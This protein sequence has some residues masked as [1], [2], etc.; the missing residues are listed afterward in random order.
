MT[1]Q[2]EQHDELFKDPDLSTMTM[3]ERQNPPIKAMPTPEMPLRDWTLPPIWGE[4]IEAN[5]TY[6]EV[7][8][9]VVKDKV[10]HSLF[11]MFGVITMPNIALVLGY[12]LFQPGIWLNNLWVLA[13][14]IILLVGVIIFFLVSYHLLTTVFWAPAYEPIRFCRQDRKVYCYRSSRRGMNGMGVYH[15][16]K[17]EV[18]VYDWAQCRAEVRYA[19]RA[20]SHYGL[21][22]RLQLSFLDPL[23]NEVIQRFDIGGSGHV[24]PS[25]SRVYLWETIRRYMEK[26]PD[27][28]PAPVVAKRRTT[29]L[30]FIDTVNPFSMPARFAPRHGRIFGY[31]VAVPMWTLILMT[32]PSVLIHWMIHKAEHKVDWGDFAHTVFYLGPG[33]TAARAAAQPGLPGP[34]EAAAEVRRQ[35]TAAL[36]WLASVVLQ[37]ATIARWVA[38]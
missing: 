17:K 11:G 34:V 3:G 14:N 37:V 2:A 9:A 21:T 22:P 29:L 12:L 25:S 13:V 33:D 27:A 1:T 23:T 15:F 10:F 5:G 24:W 26:G 35:K 36:W 20:N 18:S 32:L 4:V 7:V 30:D 6:L 8:S 28:I 19:H 31:L 16:G 38:E